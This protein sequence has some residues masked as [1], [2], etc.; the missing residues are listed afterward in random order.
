LARRCAQND[1]VSSKRPQPGDQLVFA[2]GERKG[3]IIAAADVQVGGP[4][5]YAF[6]IE[7]KS[8]LCAKARA[9]TKSC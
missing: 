8:R 1:D 6:P 7:P 4:Q 9:S 3:K 2:D 5:L